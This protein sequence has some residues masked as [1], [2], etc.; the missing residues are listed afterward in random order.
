MQQLRNALIERVQIEHEQRLAK[1]RRFLAVEPRS[2]KDV[3]VV[4]INIYRHVC[5][6]VYIYVIY[7]YVIYIYIY[8]Y[9]LYIYIHV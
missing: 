7:I 9:I 4:R 8:I 1:P 2:T 5:T 6:C 3:S